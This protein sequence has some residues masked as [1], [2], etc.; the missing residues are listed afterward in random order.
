M[1]VI[2][3]K[4]GDRLHIGD[5]ICVTILSVSG[6]KVSVGVEAPREIPIL[7]GELAETIEVN[8]AASEIPIENGAM[9]GLAALLKTAAPKA[10]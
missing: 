3:R 8:K 4:S 1:L 7:R 2:S 9:R 10:E 5:S 6:D